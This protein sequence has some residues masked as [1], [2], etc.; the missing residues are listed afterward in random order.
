M[1]VMAMM[2]VEEV[3]PRKRKKLQRTEALATSFNSSKTYS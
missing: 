2:M 1:E 3:M